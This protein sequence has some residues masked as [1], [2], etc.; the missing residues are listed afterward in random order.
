MNPSPLWFATRGAG[1]VSLLLL[2]AVTVLGVTGAVGWRTPIWPRFV[3]ATLHRNLS[4]LALAL[5][6]VHIV[7]AVLDPFAHLGWRDAVIPV[8]GA[9]RPIW[10]GMGVLAIEILVAVSITSMLRNRIGHRLWR[11]VH[12]LA[13]ASWP[14]SIVHGLGTG[15]DARESWSVMLNVACTGAVLAAVLWRVAAAQR[16]WSPVR[17]W[18]ATTSGM[19]VVVLASWSLHGPMATDWSS[20]AA[21]PQPTPKAAAPTPQVIRDAVDGTMASRDG[22]TVIA[23]RDRRDPTLTLVVQSTTA[24]QDSPT[25][26]VVHGS[27]VVCEGPATVGAAI[28]AACR[29]GR[30][31]LEVTGGPKVVTGQMVAWG[32][33]LP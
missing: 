27:T 14:L 26:R 7:T 11:T 18:L 23:L 9:Y 31:H 5:L 10:L 15:S 19:A 3:T 22:V 32:G 21:A 25:L 16:L 8:G 24:S 13:Y 29:T 4:L 30:I 33:A 20:R 12:W 17:V 28:D 6:V 2:T 1:T